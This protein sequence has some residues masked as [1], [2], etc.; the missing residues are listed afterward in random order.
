MHSIVLCLSDL[1]GGTHGGVASRPIRSTHTHTHTC[2]WMYFGTSLIGV[3]KCMKSDV[4]VL[5]GATKL[6]IN[7]VL[8]IWFRIR[9]T[10]ASLYL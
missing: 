4:I 5:F 1:I 3:T 7:N 9:S 8:H 10:R 6:N 2:H